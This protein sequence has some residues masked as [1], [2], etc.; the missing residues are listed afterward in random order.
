MST[1]ISVFGQ[2]VMKFLTRSG[3]EV[4]PVSEKERLLA[5]MLGFAYSVLGFGF[6]VFCLVKGVELFEFGIIDGQGTWN[7]AGFQFQ[8]LAPGT[9]LFIIGGLCFK[10]SGF[11]VHYG[12]GDDTNKPVIEPV[13]EPVTDPANER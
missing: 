9:V 13:T 6:S 12:N 1:S 7:G 5:M 10:T 2:K 3:I 4:Q 11:N 8:N